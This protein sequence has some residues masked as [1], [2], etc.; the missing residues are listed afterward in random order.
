M[1]YV[2]RPE[3]W[4]LLGLLMMLVS[5]LAAQAPQPQKPPDKLKVKV[6]ALLSAKSVKADPK[7]DELRKLLKAR[8]N[9]AVSEA[10]AYYELEQLANRNAVELTRNEDYRYRML[11][12][13]VQAGLELCDTPG[14]KVALLKQYLEVTKEDEK[15][16]QARYDAQRIPIG[17]LNRARYERLDA[18]I[19]LLRAKREADKAKDK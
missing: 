15:R 4:L 7:D 6:P 5:N 19:R 9:E 2:T 14:E 12:R 16:T 13:V 17:D 8:Y 3:P 11:Q 18:E 10:K 1:K